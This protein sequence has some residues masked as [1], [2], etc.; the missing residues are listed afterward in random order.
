MV[1]FQQS[2]ET[3]DLQFD[4]KPAADFLSFLACGDTSQRFTF[5]L[6]DD[7][8]HKRLYLAR[9]FYGTLDECQ[10]TLMMFNR[11]G[12]GIFVTVNQADKLYRKKT[13]IHFLRGIHCDIDIPKATDGAEFTLEALPLPPSMVVHTP[14]G[15][16]LYW[17]FNEPAPCDEARR[18]LHE[19]DL[20]LIQRYL[21][22]YG[23]DP[24]VCDVNRVLR[25]PGFYHCKGD[26]TLVTLDYS[27][28][29]DP[30]HRY[31]IEE[32]REAFQLEQEAT[33]REPEQFRPPAIETLPQQPKQSGGMSNYDCAV[34]Y[35]E[36]CP[37]AVQGQGGQ[38]TLFNAALKLAGFGLSLSEVDEILWNHYNPRCEPPWTDRERREFDHHISDG[39]AK[40]DKERFI[41]TARAS[42]NKHKKGKKHTD[43]P[44]DDDMPP[45]ESYEP[46]PEIDSIEHN[47]TPIDGQ[48]SISGY[49]WQDDGLYKLKSDHHPKRLAAPFKILGICRTKEFTDFGLVITFD[50][51]A[52]HSHARRIPYHALKGEGAEAFDGLCSSGLW[53]TPDAHGR[54]DL[55]NYFSLAR[56]QTETVYTLIMSTGWHGGAYVLSATETFGNSEPIYFDAPECSHTETRGSL[57]GWKENI[58]RYAQGNDW[59]MF[60]LCAAFAP[61]L[62]ELTDQQGGGFNIFGDS[63]KGKSTLLRAAASVW[64]YARTLPTWRGTSNGLESEAAIRNDGF[65]PLDELGQSTPQ[66]VGAAVYMLTNGIG[67]LRMTKDIKAQ[68]RKSWR[69]LFLSSGE[70]PL[71]VV[72]KG[73][74]T[75]IMAGQE[76][77]TVD[78]PATDGR[79]GVFDDIHHFNSPG[80]FADH[81]SCQSKQHCGYPIREFLKR[82]TSEL[83]TDRAKLE[84]TLQ[85][86]IQTWLATHIPAG[87]DPQVRRV[88]SR[89][90]LI[91]TAG[92]LAANWGIVPFGAGDV[93]AAMAALFNVWI[94]QQRGHIEASEKVKAVQALLAC[95]DTHGGSRFDGTPW[96]DAS[97]P[98][99]NRLGY[100][101][102]SEIH[103]LDFLFTPSGLREVFQDVGLDFRRAI[104]YCSD[105]GLFEK[106]A[107][108]RN[109]ISITVPD[110]GKQRVYF[111]KASALAEAHEK[112]SGLLG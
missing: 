46:P 9:T 75:Q 68:A 70:K 18:N 2:P 91:A 48:I 101:K 98:V 110:I 34:K 55:V 89:F 93:T 73:G 58:A 53:I 96:D 97:K 51:G 19:Q 81:L 71:D 94:K 11:D 28:L 36:H 85:K 103:E 13:D 26:P 16:H 62:L 38:T 30:V 83:Q 56:E 90:A 86:D 43:A 82:L 42:A 76:V 47:F 15:L 65:L 87:A 52:S 14:H 77:R 80:E 78:I 64:G 49:V 4:L 105:A 22:K 24:A 31:T 92:V 1:N 69:L 102:L 21:A 23:A 72:L 35:V 5:Q 33:I 106:D 41:D 25:I 6:F 59:L 20:K 84:T 79:Y 61:P 66:E 7:T 27:V 108:G 107:G 74:K 50:A 45:L 112:M 95:I 37:P 17:L 104:A 57:E 44:Q 40:A 63:S 12:C 54:R 60:A 10:D 29:A 3:V 67:K 109:S 88:G 100:R 8:P 111:V 99:F 39:Y 32:I